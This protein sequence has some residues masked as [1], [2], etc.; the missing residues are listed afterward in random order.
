MRSSANTGVADTRYFKLNGWNGKTIVP[1][2]DAR[3]DRVLELWTYGH[4]GNLVTHASGLECMKAGFSLVREFS[5]RIF[6]TRH[7]R[8]TEQLVREQ[9]EQALAMLDDIV[10]AATAFYSPQAAAKA[11]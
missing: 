3:P 6:Q 11:A 7:K 10:R 1:L 5:Q 4:R 2:P 8:V 9:H